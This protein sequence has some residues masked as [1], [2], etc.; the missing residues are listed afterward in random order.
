MPVGSDIR[1]GCELVLDADAFVA[2]GAFHT[3][4]S[5]A[6]ATGVHVFRCTRV[7]D[8]V[9][10]WVPLGAAAPELWFA[11]WRAVGRAVAGE[12]LLV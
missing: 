11:G 3:G 6:R 12:R 1:P 7:D 10:E 9:S 2:G 4:S 8:G 5:A